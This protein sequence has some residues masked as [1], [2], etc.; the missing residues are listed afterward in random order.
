MNK[1][2]LMGNLTKDPVVRYTQ[3]GMAWTSTSIAV[4]R[5]TK[6]KSA[7]FFI[8]KLSRIC[9]I[10]LKPITTNINPSRFIRYI[11]LDLPVAPL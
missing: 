5:P 4:D 8:M 2:I 11:G 6:E 7:D 1:V 9:S 10:A 3:K